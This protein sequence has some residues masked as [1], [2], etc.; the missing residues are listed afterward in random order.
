M[1]CRRLQDIIKGPM[2][3][4]LKDLVKVPPKRFQEDEK[5][6]SVIMSQDAVVYHILCVCKK[7][8]LWALQGVSRTLQEIQPS[9]QKTS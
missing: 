4:I 9:F 2:S 6:S 3:N 7:G 1:S 8:A 5:W